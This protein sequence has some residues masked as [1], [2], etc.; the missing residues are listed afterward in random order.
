[1]KALSES[2]AAMALSIGV[3]QADEA[4]FLGSLEGNWQGGGTVKVR[5][6]ASPMQVS[7][8]F[9]SATT[10]RSLTLDGQCTGLLVFSRKIGADLR[11]EGGRYS[12]SYVGAGTGTAGLTGSRSGSAINL[13]ISWAKQVNGD[14]SAK[15]TIEKL[16]ETAMRLTTTDIDPKSG[17]KVT[18]SRIEL[19]RS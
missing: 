19:H 2:L 12:G 16:G 17:R 15:M 18:T 9:S 3:A 4:M 11:T 7:C 5:T 10:A 6:D 1:M 14:R 13:D 8:A